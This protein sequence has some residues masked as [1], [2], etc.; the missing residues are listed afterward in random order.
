MAELRQH[1]KSPLYQKDVLTILSPATSR[2]NWRNGEPKKDLGIP[3]EGLN[4]YTF[5]LHTLRDQE[6]TRSGKPSRSRSQT[7][8]YIQERGGD[9][10]A[11]VVVLDVV[12]TTVG[13]DGVAE[14]AA[15]G[16]LRLWQSG[17]LRLTDMGRRSMMVG[18]ERLLAFV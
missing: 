15:D 1:A 12:V 11:A 7:S 14:G 17:S 5:L 2:L 6:V 4:I 10:V 13:M 8:C 9:M 3:K 18:N 16:S